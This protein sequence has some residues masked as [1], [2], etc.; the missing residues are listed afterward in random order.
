MLTKLPFATLALA[1]AL[2]CSAAPL[3]NSSDRAATGGE[4][5]RLNKIAAS[6]KV[7]QPLVVRSS[8]RGLRHSVALRVEPARPSYGQMIGLHEHADS[9]EL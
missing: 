6:A 9:L 4:S 8:R 2:S 1:F 3:K 7:R 5:A